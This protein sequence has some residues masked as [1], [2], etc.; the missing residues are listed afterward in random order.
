MRSFKKLLFLLS[1]AERKHAALLL[2]MNLI[3]ALL[4][5]IGVAS[6]M[7]FIAVLTNPTLVETN[8]ILNS[9]FKISNIFGV[10]DNDKFLI[11]LG[12]LVFVLLITSLTFKAATTFFQLKFVQMREY[13]IGKRLFEGYLNQPYSWFLG[14]HSADLGKSI[15]S[16]VGV[17][18]N[19]G[20]QPFMVFISNTMIVI[21]LI[22]LLML[23]DPKLT[24]IVSFTL[25]VAYGLIFKL[26]R[27]FLN[28]VGKLRMI[29]NQLRFTTISEAF[30][31]VKEVKV[32]GLEEIFIKRFSN[33]AQIFARSQASSSAI[34]QIPRFALE[35]IAF[36]GII[37][38]ILFLMAKTGEIDSALPILSLYAFAGYRL[39]PAIQQ[40]YSAFTQ[41]SFV[42]PS[43][44][45]LYNDL[46]N[47]EKHNINQDQN[48]FLFNKAISL[49][50]IS[51]EYP[52]APRTSLKDVSLNISVGTTVGI[53]GATGSGKTTMVDIIL[54]LLESQKGFLEIDGQVITKKNVRSWQRIIG[55][56]PQSIYLTDDTIAA[57]IAFGVD[58]KSI[59]L[60][61]IEKVS[62]IANL[63]QFVIDELPNKYQTTIG[64]HGVRLSGGQRQRIGIARALYHNPKLLILDEATNA[65]DNITE[66]AVMEKISSIKENLTI[67]MIAHRLSTV[68]QCDNI[69]LLEKG[70]LIKQGTFKELEKFSHLFSKFVNK[71]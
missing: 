41:L 5:M 52:N 19:N 69:F 61:N 24:L 40:I 29:N 14:R 50:N 51:Y 44:E 63:H 23:V 22:S 18:I 28:H 8:I 10:N 2:I 34:S 13:S 32:G 38:L 27:K 9:I 1:P 7:P 26:V 60:Q 36:G 48:N 49:K 6:I 67:I 25:G 39:L 4:E 47:L 20:M 15:L 43:V 45:S 64:E 17:I 46:K 31:A 55:Y 21:L 57:N 11:F 59:D 37:L 16:E 66:K 53:V 33:P 35:A 70:K 30:G 3:M 56:V 62:K 68:M 42:R 71:R 54:G 58:P 65:L 12:I